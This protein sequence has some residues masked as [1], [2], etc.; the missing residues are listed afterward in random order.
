M[1][2]LVLLYGSVTTASAQSRAPRVTARIT[3]DSIMIGDRFTITIEVEKDLVQSL[4]FPHFERPEGEGGGSLECIEDAPADTVKREGR[5][6]LLRKRYVMTAFDEGIY[7]LGRPQVLYADKNIV[8]TL[9][10]PDSLRI[11]VNT[12]QIDS[13]SGNLNEIRDL[14]P[15]KTLRFRFGEV[16]GYLGYSFL[17]AI[18]IVLCVFALI[19][20]LAKRGRKISDLFRPTP[21]PPPHIVAIEALEALLHQKLWQNN[22]HKQYY[23]ALS[24]ILRTYLDG[25]FDIGAMEMTTDEI[26]DA[27]RDVELP[28]KSAMDLI[29]V[30]RDADLVKFAKAM[31]EA[32]E[33]EAAYNKAYYFV[34]ETKPV[35]ESDEQDKEKEAEV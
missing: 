8:D 24:D 34:E 26:V 25:R 4:A 3:P 5:S 31:P 12:F 15:Q 35:E 18:I 7:S 29:A 10:A 33:N 20:Y 19:R 11:V 30:L 14:K 27:I 9:Y 28:Q 6:L 2:A 21:P 23:S 22:K 32:A 13:L 16:S 1:L 17:A